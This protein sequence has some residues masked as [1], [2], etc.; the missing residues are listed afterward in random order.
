MK[1]VLLLR[2]VVAGAAK[3]T[4]EFEK[5]ADVDGD[6]SVNMKDIL[7]LRKILAGAA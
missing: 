5:Y 7:Q 3:L 1:D 4:P 2:K 6:G